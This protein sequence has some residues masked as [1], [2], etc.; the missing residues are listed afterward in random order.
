MSTRI[1]A[2]FSISLKQFGVGAYLIVLISVSSYN[3]CSIAMSAVFASQMPNDNSVNPLELRVVICSTLAP[4][5]RFERTT[6]RLG[7][8]RSI[9]VSYGGILYERTQH[10][11]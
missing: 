10:S 9:L 6:F 2:L 7:G 8:E 1:S 5:A 4:P 11:H 3:L